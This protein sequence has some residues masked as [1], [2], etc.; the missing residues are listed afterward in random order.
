MRR[1]DVSVSCCVCGALDSTDEVVAEEDSPEPN[2][3]NEANRGPPQR[4]L[5]LPSHALIRCQ[6]RSLT[7][8]WM[9]MMAGMVVASW[10]VGVSGVACLRMMA[11]KN[12]CSEG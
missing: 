7:A 12:W 8:L 10:A 2:P 1:L 4:W 3:R 6:A 5:V 9:G 11:V